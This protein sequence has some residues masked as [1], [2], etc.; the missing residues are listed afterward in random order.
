MSQPIAC[1]LTAADHA[2]RAAETA[3]LARRALRSRERTADGARLTFDPSPET[4]RRLRDLVAAEAE[5]CPFLRL[6]LRAAPDALVLEIAG[7]AEA[8]P[9]VAELFDLRV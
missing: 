8:E 1:T 2:A 7:P 5:C 9:I 4:E 3:D 6:D